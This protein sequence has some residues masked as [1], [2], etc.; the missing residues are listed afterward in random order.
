[1]S[2]EMFLMVPSGQIVFREGDDGAE[3]YIIESGAIDILRAARGREPLATLG[4]GDF[5]GEMAILEDQPRFATAVA[6]AP[7]KL[8]RI[9]RAA[10]PGVIA[11]NVEIAIRIMRK[12]AGRLR[13]AESGGGDTTVP[14]PVEVRR[15][16]AEFTPLP[17]A[18][19][20]RDEGDATTATPRLMHLATQTLFSLSN[21]QEFLV[22]RPDPVTGTTPEVNLGPLDAQ[23]SLSRRHAKI[24]K[25]GT[26]WM[27]REEVGTLNGTFHNGQRL[28]PGVAVRFTIGDTLRFG[29]VDLAVQAEP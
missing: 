27:V 9:D 29:S 20:A 28:K 19:P 14:Y 17:K 4:P 13:R 11:G 7:T 8:L 22:G 12:L 1:M 21:G 3:M 16:A 2:Q 10:F 6:R 5:F 25:E 23:R 26:N 15:A 18:P 24:L